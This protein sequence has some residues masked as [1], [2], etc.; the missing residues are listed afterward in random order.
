MTPSGAASNPG[1][2]ELSGAGNLPS[3][4]L[5]VQLFPSFHQPTSSLLN[6]HLLPTKALATV[7]LQCLSSHM[8]REV[9]AST[10]ERPMRSKGE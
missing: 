6:G 1:K 9:F 8:D 5:A 10:T 7:S 3:W 4:T 2:R